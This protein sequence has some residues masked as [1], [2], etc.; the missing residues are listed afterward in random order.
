MS[1]PTTGE[2]NWGTQLNQYITN[3]VLAQANAAAASIS[4]HQ[5]ASDP[6]GDRAYALGIVAPLTS[7][8]N[9]PNGFL[10]LNGAGRIPSSTLPTGG[11]RTSSFDVVADYSAPTNGTA[12][13]TYIQ[14]ALTAC[15]ATGGGEVWVGDGN[16]GID[17]VLY[18]PSNTWLHLS[19]GA[20]MTRIVNTGTGQAP[21]YMV[22]NFNGSSSGSGSNNILIEG[23][24]WVFDSQAAAGTPM[25]FVDGDNILVRNTSIRTLQNSPAV[26]FAGCTN[27]DTDEV[28]FSTS[29]PSSGRSSYS[30]APPAVRIEVAAS[31][32]IS[33]LNAAIYTGLGCSSVG[34]H[35][36]KITGATASDGTGPYTAFG[37]MVGT[38]AAVASV[39]HTNIIVESCMAVA[40]PYN[41]VYPANWQTMAVVNNQFSLNNGQAAVAAWN[42]SAPGSTNQV[43]ANNTTTST[44][45][46]LDAYYTA[47]SG[48]RTGTSLS[49]DGTLQVTVQP[50]AVYEVR[51][52]IGY[53]SSNKSLKYDF[54]LPSGS[55]NYTTT[56]MTQADNLYNSSFGT[57][58]LYYS[59]T[60]SITAGSPDTADPNGSAVQVLGLLQ[61]GSSGGTF[62]LEW[63]QS[64][65]APGYPIVL[66]AGSY[67]YLNRVA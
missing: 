65:N 61:V 15:G 55:F 56:R 33:G 49:L 30:S 50:N 24:S 42:P 21:P 28:R 26:L 14:N 58:N 17:Q 4:S 51:A 8:V 34:V 44:G 63:C 67:L 1:L 43:I 7:G 31:S 46:N 16:F 12:A 57:V 9:G 22:A 11:G 47:N 48:G 10:Q 3:V 32:V 41:G 6:H 40:L 20:V 66:L 38:T 53:S 45:S 35:G 18:C 29:S 25:A 36:C 54:S 39:W 5:V 64:S 59:Q 37:G 60:Y 19:P 27:S 2:D 23:G 13:S 52:G 62:G